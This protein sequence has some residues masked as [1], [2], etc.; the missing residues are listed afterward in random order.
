MA[1]TTPKLP[2]F[3]SRHTTKTFLAKYSTSPENEDIMRNMLSTTPPDE[4]YIPSK[5]IHAR[6]IQLEREK[7]MKR[8]FDKELEI[9]SK[10]LEGCVQSM[11]EC[12]V[13][14]VFVVTD[15]MLD[16]NKVEDTIVNYFKFLGYTTTSKRFENEISVYMC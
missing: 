14:C 4:F 7:F 3:S 5:K 12:N 15:Y 2:V 6:A 11:K 13:E 10:K 9:I 16:I 8:Y 1:L